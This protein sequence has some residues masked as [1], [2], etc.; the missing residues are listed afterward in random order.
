MGENTKIEWATHTFNPWRGC[1]KVSDGCKFCY[2]ETFSRRNPA[3]L[4]EWGMNGTR[5]IASESMWRQPIKW[6]RDAEDLDFRPRVFCA[7]LADVF[8][9]RRDLES[10]RMRLLRLV[11]DTPN[12]DWLFL[13]KRPQNYCEAM[14]LGYQDGLPPNLW[15]GTSIE[16]QAAMV[17]L[18][19]L[20]RIPAHILFVSAEPLLG[21]IGVVQCGDCGAHYGVDGRCLCAD[22]NSIGWWIAGGESG[23]KARPCHPDWARSLR[24]QCQSAGIDF[25]WKQWGETVRGDQ[26][27]PDEWE[28]IERPDE[29]Q[30]YRLPK[31][32]AGRF[33]DGR[34]WSEVPS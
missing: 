13:T 7:S 31:K 4:G 24:D 9:L 18:N 23:P 17:R 11:V 22:K 34:T 21:L 6:N 1:T 16:N 28:A 3:M 14:R 33:L 25:F 26:M 27:P 5:V 15:L 29:N 30:L 2:A 20:R 10:P 19:H 12:L 32:R 8:E